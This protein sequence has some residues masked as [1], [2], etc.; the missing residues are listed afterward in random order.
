MNNTISKENT[1]ASNEKM[2]KGVIVAGIRVDTLGNLL[3][4]QLLPE[5]KSTIGLLDKNGII[6]YNGNMSY[7]ASSQSYI[8]K[9]I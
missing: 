8:G 4:N 7:T 1:T 5:F 3:K 2:F 6:I 9:Y